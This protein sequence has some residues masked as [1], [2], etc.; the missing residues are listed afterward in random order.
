MTGAVAAIRIRYDTQQ[1]QH[2]QKYSNNT[3]TSIHN[4]IPCPRSRLPTLTLQ[5]AATRFESTA[6]TSKTNEKQS[7]IHGQP[8]LVLYKRHAH[9]T[10]TINPKI[11]SDYFLTSHSLFLCHHLGFRVHSFR[12][13]SVEVS[14]SESVSVSVK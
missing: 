5:S 1:I 13:V 14:I 11:H 9:N 4:S 2:M 12:S 3:H 8:C 10:R 6:T 7:G